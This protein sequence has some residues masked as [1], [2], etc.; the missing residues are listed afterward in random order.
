MF[1]QIERPLVYR[2][3]DSA[4][5]LLLQVLEEQGTFPLKKDGFRL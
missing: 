3:G 5:K 4:P 1:G 2:I